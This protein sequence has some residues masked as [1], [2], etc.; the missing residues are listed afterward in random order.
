MSGVWK[1]W[2]EEATSCVGLCTSRHLCL[3]PFNTSAHPNRRGCTNSGYL[4]HG[5]GLHVE[6][7]V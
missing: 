2:L 5:L 6:I 3:L 7:G 4:N 1:G